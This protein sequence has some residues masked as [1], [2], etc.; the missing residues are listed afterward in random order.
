MDFSETFVELMARAAVV[1]NYVNRRGQ[2]SFYELIG[3]IKIGF[4][5]ADNNSIQFC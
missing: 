1:A 2:Y 3:I 5:N 4:I